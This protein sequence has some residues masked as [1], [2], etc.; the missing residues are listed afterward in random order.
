MKVYVRFDLKLTTKLPPAKA[1]GSLV[2]S[3]LYWGRY[4][5]INT[6]IGH[7]GLVR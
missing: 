7:K 2:L 6:N 3:F 1:G 5:I 4:V